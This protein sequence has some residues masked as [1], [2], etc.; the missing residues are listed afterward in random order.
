MQRRLCRL[1]LTLKNCTRLTWNITT[2][3]RWERNQA[4]RWQRRSE[5]RQ[6]SNAM[7]PHHRLNP[8]FVS[9]STDPPP[10]SVLPMYISSLQ[11]FPRT[12]IYSICHYKKSIFP[13]PSLSS[14]FPRFTVVMRSG[15]SSF[16]RE[17]GGIFRT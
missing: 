15:E 6:T 14:L 16:G 9:L 7:C 17:I 2:P 11:I 13:P 10:H 4:E 8:I 1:A 3:L 12:N 5:R